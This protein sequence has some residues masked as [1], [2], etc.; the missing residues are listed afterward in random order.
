MVASAGVLVSPR[1]ERPSATGDCAMLRGDSEAAVEWVQR[2]R[3]GKVPQSGALIRLGGALEL[4]SDWNF[5]AIRVRGVC[6]VA[7]DGISHWNRDLALRNLQSVRPDVPRQT[8][9][10]GEAGTSLCTS[11]LASSSYGTQLRS[12][13]NILIWGSLAPG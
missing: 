7:A 13:L 10:L 8:Q 6:N 3:W 1:A 2:C 5:D 9:D 11:V 4:S 12:R